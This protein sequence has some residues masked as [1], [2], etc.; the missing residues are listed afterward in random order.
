MCDGKIWETEEITYMCVQIFS[1]G[2]QEIYSSNAPPTNLKLLKSSSD[3]TDVDVFEE[4]SVD[5]S[6]LL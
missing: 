4:I 1:S 5:S 6:V 2:S 3:D